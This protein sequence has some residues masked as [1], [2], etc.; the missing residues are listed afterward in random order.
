MRRQ[1]AGGQR[2]V[3]ADHGGFA[4]QDINETTK[5]DDNYEDIIP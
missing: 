2:R 4:A 5:T 1:P 3:A